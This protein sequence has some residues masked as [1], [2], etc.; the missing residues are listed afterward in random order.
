[1]S[2]LKD[3]FAPYPAITGKDICN[4]LKAISKTIPCQI[5]PLQFFSYLVDLSDIEFNE[6]KNKLSENAKNLLSLM[7]Q[8][9]IDDIGQ[10]EYT[11]ALRLILNKLNNGSIELDNDCIIVKKI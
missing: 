6:D 9:N 3:F 10:T 5:E 7:F 4:S 2:A 11:P 1:M 8:K